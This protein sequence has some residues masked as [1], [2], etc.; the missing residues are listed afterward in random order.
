MLGGGLRILQGFSPPPVEPENDCRSSYGD[1]VHDAGHEQVQLLDVLRCPQDARLARR[2]HV[3][4]A[5][6][7]GHGPIDLPLHQLC[8][9]HLTTGDADWVR[10]L[11]APFVAGGLQSLQEKSA[12][13]QH[14]ERHWGTTKSHMESNRLL[15][16]PEDIGY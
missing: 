15:M 3:F 5:S 9:S 8:G 2:T 10:S 12:G 7:V 1:A 6:D 16:Q 11:N 14:T 13:L 4:K